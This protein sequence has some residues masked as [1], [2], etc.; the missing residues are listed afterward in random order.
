MFFSVRSVRKT[1]RTVVFIDAKKK[2]S[3]DAVAWKPPRKKHRKNLPRME[4]PGREILSDRDMILLL[5]PL[6]DGLPAVFAESAKKS[7]VFLFW[8]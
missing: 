1:G 6:F 2:R 4:M 8:I 3:G 5:C 7:I